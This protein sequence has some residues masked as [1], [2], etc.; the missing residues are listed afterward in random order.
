MV[1]PRGWRRRLVAGALAIVGLLGGARGVY[2]LAVGRV[3]RSGVR[4]RRGLANWCCW[5]TAASAG[6]SRGCAPSSSA[7][8][9]SR[10]SGP[11][12]QVV[13]FGWSPASDNILRAGSARHR[14]RRQRSA[15]SSPARRSSSG[16]TWWR[17][18]P[19]PTCSIRS[20]KSW[21]AARGRTATGATAAG[22]AEWAT[23][24]L[25]VR[26]TFLDPIGLRGLFERGWGAARARVA[27]PTSPWPTSTPTMPRRRPTACCDTPAPSTSPRRASPLAIAAMPIAGRSSTTASDCRPAI[28]RTASAAP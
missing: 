23:P 12:V 26:M 18:A 15:R 20:A 11:S 5:C 17:T 25:Q 9:S 8:G 13:R 24:A 28:C 2:A 4:S 22:I 6:R 1:A 19:A 27:A 7:S 10:R 16:F 14:D 21:R 3:G